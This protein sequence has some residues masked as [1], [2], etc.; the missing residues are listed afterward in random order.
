MILVAAG[1]FSSDLSAQAR[2]IRNMNN[3]IEQSR[4]AVLDKMPKVPQIPRVP[5][6]PV[7]SD[8]RKPSV[9]REFRPK[10]LDYNEP[11]AILSANKY[12]SAFASLSKKP[13]A[14]G[15]DY[16]QLYF[17]MGSDSLYSPII[18]NLEYKTVADKYLD[19]DSPTPE[20]L[21]EVLAIARQQF[22]KQRQIGPLQTPST[23]LLERATLRY[24]LQVLA[25]DS[26][27]TNQDAAILSQIYDEY[28]QGMTNEG[29]ILYYY[30]TGMYEYAIPSLNRYYKTFEDHPVS[31]RYINRHINEITPKFRLLE[32]CY[33]AIGFTERRDSLIASPTYQRIIKSKTTK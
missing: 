15:D 22:P 10:V 26:T 2:Q 19:I 29:N 9:L 32:R 30:L 5:S 4:R 31:D 25:A 21:A 8:K 17:T 18:Y 1:L 6:P 28:R 13:T 23:L 16:L 12:L 33:D 24:Y 14:T 11:E 3:Q 7:P 27:F 20:L